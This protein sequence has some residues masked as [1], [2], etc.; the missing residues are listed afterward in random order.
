MRFTR[1]TQGQA[2]I[3]QGAGTH[4]EGQQL[5]GQDVVD[6]VGRDLEF[7][8]THGHTVD[9]GPFGIEAAEGL[10]ECRVGPFPATRGPISDGAVTL[11][12]SF[13]K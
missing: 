3:G 2:R 8:D 11:K 4:F 7:A 12:Y 1:F 5:L 6:F 13:F 9:I 10:D